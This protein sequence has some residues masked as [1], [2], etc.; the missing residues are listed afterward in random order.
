LLCRFYGWEPR[1]IDELDMHDV[2]DYFNAMCAIEA[3]EMLQSI[4]ISDMP[5]LEKDKRS[6]VLRPLKKAMKP[7][8]EENQEKEVKTTAEYAQELVRSLNGRR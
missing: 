3:K 1:V 6:K 7:D 5:H 8:L 4:Q 2:A